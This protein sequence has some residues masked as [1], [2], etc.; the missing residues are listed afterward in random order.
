MPGLYIVISRAPG[1][2][3]TELIY[4]SDHQNHVD[5]R[6]AEE[7]AGYGVSSSQFQQIEDPYPGSVESLPASLAGEITRLRFTLQQIISELSGGS[8]DVNWYDP[9][10]Y[11]GIAFIGARV[12]R[13]STVAIPNNSVTV[14]SF[15]GGT[16]DFNSTI[17]AAVWDDMVQPTRFTA[18][19]AGR[20]M[21]FFFGTWASNATG[22]RQLNM[23]KN[24]FTTIG[25]SQ[26]HVAPVGNVQ[27][28][29]ITGFFD[30]VAN[31]YIQFSVF[32]NSGGN[33]AFNAQAG[34]IV[35]LGGD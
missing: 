9:L 8:T 1:T 29:C 32:Q 4:N 35:F 2:M 27:A 34:G 33:L 5:G 20:Y 28:Q 22:K 26:T 25:D 3:I 18:P 30:M 6:S 16:V 15:S 23:G 7:M 13:A 24:S 17:P 10:N 11:P 31:D 14:I 21:A 12:A 19:V